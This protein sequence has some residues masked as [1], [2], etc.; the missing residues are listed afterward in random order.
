MTLADP[1]AGQH[2]WDLAVGDEV[3]PHCQVQSLLG[4]GRSYEAYLAFDERLLT[5]VV[6]KVVRP[7]LVDDP[8]TL[9]GLRR[10]VDLIGR[11]S[12][13]VVVR[14]FHAAT[15]GDRPYVALERL[16][17]PRL[18]TLLRKH[19]AL[20]LDQ[21]LPL[22]MEL[23]S[24]LHYLHGSDVV[25]LDVKPSNII[26]G[27]APR[28]IDLSIARSAEA[29][30]R[31]DHVVGTDRYMAPE[32][33]DPPRTGNPGP[34]SDMW[35]LGATMFE[36]IAGLRA[37]PDGS[38]RSDSADADRWPQLMHGPR[39]L[40]RGTP[41]PL[42]AVVLAALSSDPRLRPEPVEMFDVLESMVAM[43]PRPTLGLFRPGGNR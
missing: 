13:P 23:C 21:L 31:L 25:H 40:P 33:C 41:A 8:S 18:S 2:S 24:A 11:L 9:N 20:P 42:A 6:V 38:T 43:L 22:G 1:I 12:H 5:P 39:D 34:A 26:M 29:A 3:V 10:E 16:L 19:G 35:G 17:G 7:H 14:G 30:A 32:Q 4:G 36:A 28:L 15:N 27:Q 37:F